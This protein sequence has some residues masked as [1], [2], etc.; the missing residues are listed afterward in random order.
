MNG[1]ILTAAESD[2]WT[3]GRTTYQK[4][5]KHKDRKKLGPLRV[6]KALHIPDFVLLLA[7]GGR[8]AK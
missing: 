8:L 1:H 7:K 3:L 2:L 6:K 5:C 4:N